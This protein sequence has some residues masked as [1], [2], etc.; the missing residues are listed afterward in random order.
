MRAADKTIV[1]ILGI[2]HA[3][4]AVQHAFDIL[5]ATRVE[6]AL[7]PPTPPAT[8]LQAIASMPSRA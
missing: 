7:R 2:R 1:S 6:L 8:A 3:P 5:A 4:A